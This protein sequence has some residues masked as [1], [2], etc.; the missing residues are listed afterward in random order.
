MARA[1]STSGSRGQRTPAFGAPAF[2]LSPD[3][4]GSIASVLTSRLRVA[5]E[6]TEAFWTPSRLRAARHGLVLAGLLLCIAQLVG[7]ALGSEDAPSY[8]RTDLATVYDGWRVGQFGYGY[9]PAFALAMVPLTW[10]PYLVF[11]ALWFAADALV[12]AWLA[13]PVPKE[14]R[15]A[16]VLLCLPEAI[17]GN[18]H[19]LLAGA[20]AISVAVPAAW[21]FVLLTKVT[22]GVALAYHIGRGELR[23]VGVAIL[24]TVAIAFLAFI[25]DPGLWPRWFDLLRANEATQG[26][27][28]APQIPLVVRVATAAVVAFVGGRRGWSP[29]IPIAAF[30]ALPH[31]VLTGATILAAIPRLRLA[32]D[33][34]ATAERPPHLSPAPDPPAPS[35]SS[36]S[37]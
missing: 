26:V 19:L 25:V 12:L 29:A 2:A 5:R 30:V 18:I 23:R 11:R 9:S 10:L 35:P 24:A 16:F 21:S 14:W 31:I 32:A 4:P 17:N 3:R 13:G 28:I 34:M 33:R 22:P 8:W 20:I 6:R 27:T 36:G 7:V 1:A 37:L 15:P